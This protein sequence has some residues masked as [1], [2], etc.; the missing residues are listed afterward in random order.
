M[1]EIRSALGRG[2]AAAVIVIGLA[3][4][5]G[6]V[7][8]DPSGAGG[9][10]GASTGGGSAGGLPAPACAPSEG[11]IV[12]ATSKGGAQSLLAIHHDG[13]WTQVDG[14][15]PGAVQVATYMDDYHHLGAFW[16]DNATQAHFVTT[17]DGMSFDHF[18]AHNWVPLAGRPLASAGKN[19]LLGYVDG[20]GDSLA[21]FDTDAFDW[22]PWLSPMP[23][24]ASSAVVLPSY[25]MVAVGIDASSIPVLLCDAISSGDAWGSKHCRDDIA[26]STSDELPSPPR[27]V[28]LSNGD[29]VVVYQLAGSSTTIGATTLHAGVWSAP[30][31]IQS[32]AVGGS[33]A[34][35]ATPGDDVVVGVISHAGDVSALRYAP[36]AG[37]SAPIPI[38]SGAQGWVEIGA[39][40]GIC[41]DD[42][43]IAY[44]TDVNKVRV[45]RVR[46]DA[47]E[48]RT[49]GAFIGDDGATSV[50]I[51]TRSAW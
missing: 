21:W 48:A 10:V 51:S 26:L 25:E 15:L 37:W 22:N 1:L 41:G 38:D 31:T 40:P 39:A 28:A 7:D 3:A 17:A 9:N 24:T 11:A 29:A 43:L 16:I 13:A 32:A 36:G 42:A 12:A 27:V 49:V 50:H 18:D 35:T 44:P 6:S 34:A 23:L 47:V 4:C 20:V 19:V 14:V 30:Q 2:I 46:G 45:A 33:F 5:G 8:I